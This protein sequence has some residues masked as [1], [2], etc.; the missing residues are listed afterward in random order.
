[1]SGNKISSA[2]RFCAM[3]IILV[4]I[5]SVSG[6]G[7]ADSGAA[8]YELNI[9]IGSS[10]TSIDP[11]VISDTGSCIA[12]S[13]FNATLY[14][15]NDMRELIPGLAEYS[16][17]SDDGLTVTYHL[18]EG[19]KW[20][21]GSPITADDLVCAF[22]RLADPATKSGSVYLITDCCMLM[23]AAKVNSGE[24]PVSELGVSAPDMLTFEIKLEQP[25]PYLNSLLTLPSF[26]PCSREFFGS[27][28]NS[29]ATSPDT[30]LSSGPYM[31][32][33]YEPLATQIH[34][35]KNPN[36]YK[37]EEIH[38]PGVNLQLVA[39]NQQA[40]MCYE[41]G[42]LDII[43]VSGEIG[44]LTEG[45]PHVDRFST[46]Q[47]YRIDFDHKTNRYLQNRDLRIA[48]SKSID[49]DS[50]AKNVLRSGYKGLTRVI[51][52]DFCTN[53]D[54]SDFAEDQTLYDEYAGYDKQKACEHWEK[55]LGELGVSEIKLEIICESGQSKIAEAIKQQME[56]A[57]PGFELEIVPLPLKEWL[58]RMYAGRDY[59]LI[60]T[61]WVADY[62]DP[63]SLY[64][65]CLG[66][67]DKNYYS[68]PE[69][70]KLY[71]D[72]QNCRGEER[73]RILHR[74]EDIIMEEQAMIPLFGGETT[75]LLRD[76]VSGLEMNPTGVTLVVTGLK[77]EVS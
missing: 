50:I 32:D 20:S 19:L 9:G 33:R 66:D 61:S 4:F 47:V 38:L 53:S 27:C 51:P 73:D 37:T 48:L 54:G 10:P 46:A 75:Y 39:D 18:R 3:L 59:D 58:R 25:C 13:F 6:C 74:A 2:R 45:D 49:R 63:T 5:L 52:K 44:E 70:D 72:S 31:L 65:S 40:L 76:G 71:I 36:Y 55:A 7:S 41:S 64:Q 67:D 1:M 22:Q 24:L 17:T 14:E 26:A 35:V 29:Y 77:K 69:I 23:N 42:L 56:T 62:A 11:Q 28:G 16:E 60:L 43:K 34:F 68:N 57:L 8:E 21:N 15:Y 30:I 12:A